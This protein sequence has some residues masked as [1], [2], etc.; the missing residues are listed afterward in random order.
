MEFYRILDDINMPNRWFLGRINFEIGSQFW[1]YISAGTVET[2][3][4]KLIV[5]LREFGVPLGI[6][7]ADFGL[8]VVNSKVAALF[9][10]N[11]VQKIPI[12]IE[13]FSN[14]DLFYLL[15]IKNEFECVNKEK[16]EFDIWELNN[17]IRPDKAGQY[18][19]IYKLV[20]D[21][22]LV[23]GKNIFRLKNY[24]VAIIINEVLKRKFE[25]NNVSGV[26]FKLVT[27]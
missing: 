22:K 12:E 20:L 1:K 16:S 27:E 11:E 19:T 8:L 10:E 25:E 23:E 5:S 24:N 2:P 6:T 15:I 4:K 26:K 14:R 13:N 7:M 17:D 21:P 9:S 3:S 18:K